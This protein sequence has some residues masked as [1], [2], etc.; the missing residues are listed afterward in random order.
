[1]SAL[2]SPMPLFF[3]WVAVFVTAIVAGLGPALMVVVL[4]VAAT[5]YLRFEPVGSLAVRSGADILR[6][7][8]FASF[9]TA[10]SV[11]A[12]MRR[13][14]EE[15]AR[16]SERR[17]RS[18]VE[19]TPVPQVVWTADATGEVRSPEGWSRDDVHPDDLARTTERWK[20]SVTQRTYYEDEIRVRTK[21]GRYRWFAIKAV[22]DADGWVGILADIHERKR[23]EENAAFINRASEVL[24]S[25]LGV[26]QT[27][28]NLAGLCVPAIADSC[29]IDVGSEAGYERMVV[30]HVDPA[31]EE[32]IREVGRQAQL[33]PEGSQVLRVLT[34]GTSE[35][36]DAPRTDDPLLKALNITSAAM[37]PM[38]ARGRT[39]G[40]LSLVYN[41]SGRRYAEEDLPLI[42]ELAR[43]AGTAL[44]NARLYEAAES[45]NRAKDEFLATLSHELRTPLTAIS[46][47]AH[48]LQ[49][50]IADQETSRLAVDTIMRSAQAQGE[51][52]DDLLD[53]SRVVAGTLHL[54]VT[55]VD[56]A[57]IVGEVVVAARPGADAKGLTVEIEGG[58]RPL[59]VRG[60]ERRLRQVVWNL[61]SNAVKFTERGGTIRIVPAARGNV[62]SVSVIDTGRGISPAFLPYVWDR[63]RQGDSSTSRQHGGLGLGLAVVRHLVEL[64]GG[65]VSV[66]SDGVGRGAMFCFE[67]PLAREAAG[68]DATRTRTDRDLLRGRRV[69]LVEDDADTRVVITAMLRQ[70]GADVLP[71]GS[72]EEA[73]SRCE[74][75]RPDAIV[76]DIAMPEEDGFALLRRVREKSDIPVVAVSAIATSADDRRR[77]LDAG[78]SEFLRKPLDPAQL[79]LAVSA[80]LR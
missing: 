7:V 74:A 36:L 76:T 26:D 11:V 65:T 75:E 10:I 5:A 9:A 37:V 62:A 71:T 56:L 38:K 55:T 23:H 51:L 14:A 67:L 25:S 8:L 79:A 41:E 70:F 44:D 50:G 54:S 4:A 16:R 66:K 80:A 32:L 12:S 63:F 52:I 42:E 68:A 29:A 69:V 64:H 39:L 20:V 15:R 59:L 28:R 40:V 17:Y 77:A 35:L 58:L 3:Y 72:V 30:K 33:K 21:D 24:S 19:A 46:G 2:V 78:F 1:L 22:P 6:L 18:L 53:L 48:M 43:R 27:L 60:D 49:L 61:V 13:R 45:A 47:W 73:V 57:S 34:S 31:K